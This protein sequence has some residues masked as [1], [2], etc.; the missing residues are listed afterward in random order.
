MAAQNPYKSRI[1]YVE[2]DMDTRGLLTCVLNLEGY[3]VICTNSPVEALRRAAEER[4][5]LLIVDN[6]LP[7][8]SGPELTKALREFDDKTPVLF[9][10][11]AA[12]PTDK[13]D[14]RLAGAQGYL[15]KPTE[16]D[17]LVAEVVRLIAGSPVGVAAGLMQDIC[18]D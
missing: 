8:M 6:W 10:S 12:Q 14:A 16:L 3:E 15:V 1:L 5:D 17:D 11:G 7:G 2:D 13:E 18:V 9:Y 4:F